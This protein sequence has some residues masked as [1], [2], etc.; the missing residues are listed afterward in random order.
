M[1]EI[2]RIKEVLKTKGVTQ[3]ELARAT[4]IGYKR[5]V[6]VL[7]K[8]SKLRHEEIVALALVFPEFKH[9]IAFGETIAEAGQI[10]PEIE[11]TTNKNQG[12]E[13]G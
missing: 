5:W 6:N 9:W 7:N 10:S 2:E 8:Q 11:A 13:K 1:N 12:N 4:G 3:E